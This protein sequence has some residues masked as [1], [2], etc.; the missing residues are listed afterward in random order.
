MR[1]LY[2]GILARGRQVIS[3]PRILFRKERAMRALGFAFLAA[4]IVLL[5]SMPAVTQTA[6][7]LGPRDLA[8]VNGCQMVERDGAF[9]LSSPTNDRS[10]VQTEKAFS[11]PL[12][13]RLRART[14]SNN[15]RL[16]YNAG[17]VIFNWECA[18]EQLRVHDPLTDNIK[19]VP[20]KGYVTPGEWHDITWEIEPAWMRI[21]LDDELRYE[22]P[23]N[24]AD[25]EAPIG[26]G[27]AFGSV[28]SV[29]SLVIE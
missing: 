3:N 8:Q 19:P 5:I 26:V 2:A 21:T 20:E 22:G 15:I 27:P 1:T 9:V 7:E 14:D 18:P 29:E 13:V 23:G 12:V 10:L 24:Y 28:V 17:M 4:G 25:I 16:Y 11:P 6:A